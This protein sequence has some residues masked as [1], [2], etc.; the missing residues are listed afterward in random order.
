MRTPTTCLLVLALLLT[1]CASPEP[2]TQVADRLLA[3]KAFSAPAKP[4]DLRLA[5]AMSDEMARFAAGPLAAEVRLHGAREGLI[6][7]MSHRSGLKL[8]YDSARTRTAGEAFEARTGNCL[9]LV[10]M[11]ASFARHLNLP[12]RYNSVYLDETWTRSNGL[13]FVT[14]HVNITLGRPVNPNG[15]TTFHEAEMVTVD[16][17]PIEETRRQ[18]ATAIDE[19]TL[20]AMYANNRAAESLASNELNDAYWWARAAI[21]TDPRWMASY[22]TL[23]V[24]YRRKGMGAPA[25]AALRYVLDREPENVQALANL[26]LVL[27]D[28]G[29]KPEAEQVTHRLSLIQP[30]PPYKYFDEG[31]AAMRVGDYKTAKNRFERELSRAAY[32]AEFHF[33]LGLAN[34]GLGNQKAT[35]EQ[36]A[37]AL[38]NSA[39]QK[40]RKLYAAKLAWLTQH[41]APAA[42]SEQDTQRRLDAYF[43]QR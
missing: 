12:M 8:D 38:E 6:S 29:R 3:D 18:R 5:M 15:S 31:V 16:F 37:L 9:S 20:L 25:E 17:V 43:R 33:W 32:V 41:T 27:T 11:T 28:V 42:D 10:L 21:Q 39:T 34:W 24:L 19:Q 35:R 7:A 40:D 4:V 13:F 22:N 1:A 36:I 23:A 2:T 26:A 30:V 14:G